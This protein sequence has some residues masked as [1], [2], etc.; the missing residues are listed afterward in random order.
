MVKPV[1]I[2]HVKCHSDVGQ[3]LSRDQTMECANRDNYN[4]WVDSTY[5]DSMLPLL[6]GMQY[7][8]HN[9]VVRL[10]MITV[11]HGDAFTNEILTLL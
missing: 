7:V 6:Q 5:T 8:N 4:T 11:L 2:A 3:R 10:L 1:I 9:Y